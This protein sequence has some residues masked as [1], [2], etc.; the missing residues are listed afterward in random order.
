MS[1]D[2]LSGVMCRPLSVSPEVCK[3]IAAF[4]LGEKQQES[5]RQARQASGILRHMPGEVLSGT[6]QHAI[7]GKDFM[8]MNVSIKT[9]H[10]RSLDGLFGC[11]GR[12]KC[13]V[14][15]TSG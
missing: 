6:V 10:G 3:V 4:Y 11:T 7:D 9:D 8:N 2:R 1:S 5:F 15:E 13:Y 14:F 12:G